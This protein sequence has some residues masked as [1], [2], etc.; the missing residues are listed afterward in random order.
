MPST[1]TPPVDELDVE[2]VDELVELVEV[3]VVV[4]V[5]GV[6]ATTSSSMPH[7]SSPLSMRK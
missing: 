2:L 3:E 4:F 1:T 7:S 5:D 6:P